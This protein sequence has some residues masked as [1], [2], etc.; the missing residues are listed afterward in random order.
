MSQTVRID[1]KHI[2]SRVRVSVRPSNFLYAKNTQNLG[3][4]DRRRVCL[5][6]WSSDAHCRQR[7][8]PS[9]LGAPDPWHRANLKGSAVC[10]CA[11]VCACVR[12][13]ACVCAC[14]CVCL[15]VCGYVCVRVCGC[16]HFMR[17]RACMRARACERACVRACV[18]AWCVF[19]IR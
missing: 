1:W 14:V 17:V 7:N 2:M 16:A 11:C 13:C 18:R 12:V 4:P 9:R 10:V 15:R 5:F 19:N 3:K 8:G 6:E